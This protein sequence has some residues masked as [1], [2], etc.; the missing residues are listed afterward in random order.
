MD[1][2]RFQEQLGKTIDTFIGYCK[3]YGRIED[4]DIQFAEKFIYLRAEVDDGDDIVVC[5][6][7]FVMEDGKGKIMA[8][9]FSVDY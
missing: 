3:E 7:E 8:L 2:I 9:H 5:K 4:L 6:Q 1:A